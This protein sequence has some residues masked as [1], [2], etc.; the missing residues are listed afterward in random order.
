MSFSPRAFLIGLLSTDA[1]TETLDQLLRGGVAEGLH[2]EFKPGEWLARGSEGGRDPAD[3]A[4]RIRKYV[5][6]FAN[7]DGGVLVVG[8]QEN[9]KT[10]RAAGLAKCPKLPGKE[11]RAQ[12]AGK[13]LNDLARHIF[14]PPRVSAI[15]GDDGDV[16]F[17]AVA[18][19]ESLVPLAENGQLKYYI[20]L[21]DGTHTV[22]D[23]LYA[24]LVMGRRSRPDLRL[25]VSPQAVFGRS[26]EPPLTITLRVSVS[27]EGLSWATGVRV[28]V[29]G[30]TAM[31]A[32]STEPLPESLLTS[33]DLRASALAHAHHTPGVPTRDHA[34]ISR[35]IADELPPFT[36]VAFD[37]PGRFTLPPHISVRWL[38]AVYVLSR[39]STPLW[40]QIE[41]LTTATGASNRH[42]EVPWAKA[43]GAPRVERVLGERP[44]VSL[45]VEP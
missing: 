5:T 44:V 18:R 4:E 31:P 22:S 42:H 24:D 28:G 10:G 40:H 8:I 41:L 13:V 17:I 14:P 32:H 16:L 7:A 35:P 29:V 12:W 36:H 15:E 11:T 43:F 38:A 45:G 33:I 19:A 30:M 1:S 21:S 27:N 6:G 25:Q 2:L 34:T 39:G 37:L 26:D 23:S 20:R 9:S 3:P